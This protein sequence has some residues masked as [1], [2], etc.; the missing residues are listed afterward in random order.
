MSDY[1][2]QYRAKRMSAT[3]VAAQIDDRSSFCCE[4][5]TAQP[6]TIIEAINRRCEMD[7]MHNCR[8]VSGLDLYPFVCYQDERYLNN[9]RGCSTFLNDLSRPFANRGLADTLTVA[10]SF[11][12]TL[13]REILSF[14]A[15][16]V[17]VSPMDEDGYFSLGLTGSCS[18]IHIERAKKILV[19]VNPNMPYS[20]YAPKVHISRVTALCEANYDLAVASL[21]EPDQTA[22][23]IGG[24]IAELI[25]DGACLQLGIGSIPDAV[26]RL[27][28]EKRH[29]GIHS[30]M[31]TDGM[32]DLIE[33]GAVDNSRKNH[34]PGASVAT[35]A[36]GSKRMYDYIN[37]NQQMRILPVEEV[38]DPRII[39]RNDNVV[40]INAALEIDLSGQ[41]CAESRGP[42]IFSGPGGQLDFVRG[43]AMSKGGQSFIAFPSTAKKGT[44]SRIKPTL[45]PGAIVTTGRTDIDMVVTE[46]GVAKLRGKT[47]AARTKELI[48]IAHPDFRDELTFEAKKMNYII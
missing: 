25:P 3:D 5:F 16:I 4:L 47:Q 41:A 11:Q 37:H 45:T 29:L 32:I 31:F 42:M 22:K 6:K 17:A 1:E 24:H 2:A 36:F 34:L 10:Y 35:F 28:K 21:G 19:E 23:A 38:N 44:M 20:P 8:V 30:E 18:N 14:D 13:F 27:L 7:Q 33:C 9:L 43:A 40:S 39:A 15:F 46:F 12:P 26:G 48:A